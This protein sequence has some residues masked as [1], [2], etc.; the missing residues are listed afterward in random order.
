MLQSGMTLVKVRCNDF[1]NAKQTHHG[2]A[3]LAR[4]LIQPLSVA[5]TGAFSV[6]T[7][8]S[9]RRESE[10]LALLAV[11]TAAAN[12]GIN[13][14]ED[15]FLFGADNDGEDDFLVVQFAGAQPAR[16]VGD[17]GVGHVDH[18]AGDRAAVDRHVVAA[19]VIP[20]HVD[21]GPVREVVGQRDAGQP[22][23]AEAA[24]VKWMGPKTAFDAIHQCL[25]TFG[26]YG[27]SMDLPHQQ[28]LRD[29]MGLEIGDGTAQIMK[30]IVARERVGRAAVQYA[31]A[32]TAAQNE[33]KVR[34]TDGRPN[35][36]SVKAPVSGI[37][38]A[39]WRSSCCPGRR[40]RCRWR[41]TSSPPP[42]C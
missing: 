19:P 41:S 38:S 24:M 34:F 28:R 26:H 31:N 29:V 37:C 7:F 11:G 36:P 33:V 21:P 1:F 2:G 5:I 30:L 23:T 18:D 15:Q 3:R 4:S 22:H 25:L 39:A 20:I 6:I 40:A 35:Q 12:S 14:Y 16:C 9:E 27:W 13:I 17:V 10:A 32:S 8:G 42:S